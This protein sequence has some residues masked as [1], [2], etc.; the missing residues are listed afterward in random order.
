MGP[1]GDPARTP[2]A[3]LKGAVRMIAVASLLS[4]HWPTVSGSRHDLAMRVGGSLARAGLTEEEIDEIIVA[5]TTEA[6]DEEVE[7]RRTAAADAASAFRTG[8]ANA[9]GFSVAPRVPRRSRRRSPVQDPW[10]RIRQPPAHRDQG[11]QPARNLHSG[12]GRPARVRRRS[13]PARRRPCAACHRG[14]HSV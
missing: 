2:F 9:Y 13:V 10:H 12:R 14:R 4:R 3:I 11:R 6:G 7:D 1:D 8:D 5:V